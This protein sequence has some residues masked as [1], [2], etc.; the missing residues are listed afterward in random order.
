M[1]IPRFV[2]ALGYI[3]DTLIIEAVEYKSATKTDTHH[4]RN[5]VSIAACVCV[6][7]YAATF[8][9]SH[10]N[11]VVPVPL[12]SSPV[13]KDNTST[14]S[15]TPNSYDD[16]FFEKIITFN[17]LDAAPIMSL[18]VLSVDDCTPMNSNELYDYY[19]INVQSAMP[20]GYGEISGTIT[21]GLYESSDMNQFVFSADDSAEIMVYISRESEIMQYIAAFYPEYFNTSTINETEVML[22]CYKYNT[23]EAKLYASFEYNGCDLIV[24]AD[25]VETSTFVAILEKLTAN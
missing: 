3:D 15:E 16:D 20:D 10:N 2:N 25:N 4:W 13:D 9:S 17:E 19:G 6:A 14:I 23:D 12:D 1:K 8:F 21:H 11:V 7:I 24:I 22:S 18:P 5:I